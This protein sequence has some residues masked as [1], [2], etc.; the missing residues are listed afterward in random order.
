MTLAGGAVAAWPV[1]ARAQQPPATPTIGFLHPG[2]PEANISVLAAFRNG[3][4]EAGFTEGHNVAI[5]F[6]WAHGDNGRLAELAGDRG[7]R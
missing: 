6:R 3:L 1:G 5:E 4:G 2:S 7:V